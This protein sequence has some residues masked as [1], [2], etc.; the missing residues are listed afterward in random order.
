MIRMGAAAWAKASFEDA[1]DK[2]GTSMTLR[3]VTVSG[4][5]SV[6]GERQYSYSDSTISALLQPEAYQQIYRD[7]VGDVVKCSITIYVKESVAVKAE[8]IIIY[9][10]KEYRIKEITPRKMGETTIYK[11][12]VLMRY[13]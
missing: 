12:I 8:D 7:S 10:G 6:Y 4:Y 3:S 13:L 9:D 11:E 2:W 5:S 1:V